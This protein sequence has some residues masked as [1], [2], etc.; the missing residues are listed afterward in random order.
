MSC[1]MN[2]VGDYYA[3]YGEMFAKF[4]KSNNF[5]LVK[6]GEFTNN[7]KMPETVEERLQL[8]DEIFDILSYIWYDN[9]SCIEKMRC[10]FEK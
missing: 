9:A 10:L 6:V 7:M 8:L 4:L 5:A 3:I 2:L 1:L